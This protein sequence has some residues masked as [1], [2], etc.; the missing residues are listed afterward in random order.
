MITLYYNYLSTKNPNF[1]AVGFPKYVID[2]L[3][4]LQSEKGLAPSTR[5]NYAT[6]VQTFLRWYR[7]LEQKSSGIEF[8]NMKISDIKLEELNGLTRTD[9]SAFL[10][11]CEDELANNKSARQNKL[12]AIRSLYTYLQNIDETHKITRNPAIE[13]TSPKRDKP[14]PKYLTLEESKH[15]LETVQKD[16][17]PN[18]CRDYCMILWFITC[19]MRLTELAGVN[20]NDVRR[21]NGAATLLLRG[22]GHK[23][24]IVALNEQCMSALEDY[25][26]F[27]TSRNPDP[28]EKALFL[29]KRG[30]RISQR[31]IEHML[32]KHLKAAGMAD[33]K[34]SPH[35]LRHT[36]AT[37]ARMCDAD[38]IEIQSQLGH[39]SIATTQIYVHALE[40]NR[41]PIDKLGSLL[42]S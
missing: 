10:S 8:E 37:L 22:K 17:S 20:L 18:G 16:S 15:L 32:E 40:Q 23:E 36:A 9:I 4:Y 27:R 26:V 33:R 1:E 35:K 19:G 13:V 25:L 34:L 11:F 41:S 14:L 31:Q 7:Y 5:V 38:I 30:G 42:E 21:N 3:R 28:N 29:S 24:R 39:S 2:W 6:A 12:S